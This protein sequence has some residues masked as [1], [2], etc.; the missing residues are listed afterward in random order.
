MSSVYCIL[1]FCV[2]HTTQSFQMMLIEEEGDLNLYTIQHQTIQGEEILK[3]KN[4]HPVN[5]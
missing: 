1:Y 4:K 3:T 5:K 2:F